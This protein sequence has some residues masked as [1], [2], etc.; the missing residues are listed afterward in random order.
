MA[1][2]NGTAFGLYVGGTLV[3]HGVSHSM[4]TNHSP[5]ET[6][7]KE[8]GGWKEIAEGL[9]DWSM[10]GTFRT[11]FSDTYGAEEAFASID[12]RSLVTVVFDSTIVGEPK[13]T[14]DGYITKLDIKAGMEDS[15]EHSISIAGSGALVK[16][17]N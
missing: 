17:T 7:S 6:T 16:A 15:M 5:R 12:T 1:V 8:S 10:E 9:R 2:K 13:W 11:D 3:G 4:N 14:G